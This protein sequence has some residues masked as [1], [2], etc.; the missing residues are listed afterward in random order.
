MTSTIPKSRISCLVPENEHQTHDDGQGW[1]D[2]AWEIEIAIYML[3]HVNNERCQERMHGDWKE[4]CGMDRA[5][6]ES[7]DK[8][9]SSILLP[10]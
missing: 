5:F 2:A 4:D 9:P 10:A 3:I 8:G 1:D 6:P 7:Q